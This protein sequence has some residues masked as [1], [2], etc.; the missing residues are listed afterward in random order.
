VPLRDLAANVRVPRRSATEAVARGLATW[1]KLSGPLQRY[2]AET[3]LSLF[4]MT[5]RKTARGPADL[6][7]LLQIAR[8]I[9][10]QL[11]KDPRFLRGCLRFLPSLTRVAVARSAV[12][13]LFRKPERPAA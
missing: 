6:W 12:G 3:L 13:R 1:E 7:R 5:I 2:E 11:L 9:N 10:P 4:G 8:Q